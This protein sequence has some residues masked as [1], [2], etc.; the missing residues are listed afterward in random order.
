MTS[1]FQTLKGTK[2]TGNARRLHELRKKL[3]FTQKE[4]ADEFYVAPGTIALWELGKREIPGPVRKL[5]EIYEHRYK[6]E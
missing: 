5:I 4:L 6:N 3:G 2:K 1:K